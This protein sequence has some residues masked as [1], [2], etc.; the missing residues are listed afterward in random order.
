MPTKAVLFGNGGH[1]WSSL[2]NLIETRQDIFIKAFNLTTDY[3]GSGGIWYRLLE[4][5]DSQLSK[6]LYG[7]ARSVLPWGDYNKI[8][9]HYA[10]KRYGSLMGQ[11][12]D[13]RSNN[14]DKHKENFELLSD[15]MALEKPV[16][17]DFWQYFEIAFNY[18]QTHKKEL[19][20][21]TKKEFCFGY[22]W[23]DYVWWN[24]GGVADVNIFYHAK[25]IIPDNFEMHYTAKDRRVLT[26][27]TTT[28]RE[29]IGEDV[30]DNA[31]DPVL[32]ES[33]RIRTKALE[34][35]EQQFEF[36]N[37]GILEKAIRIYS[38]I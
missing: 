38:R 21:E 12:L 6:L 24:L 22:P 27:V 1:G 33:L 28:Y 13:F 25:N 3:G 29:L 17:D 7:E 15:M 4:H 23:Q 16:Y 26:G 35:C 31:I 2:E 19:K 14:I 32:P 5:D 8:V 20:Y 30:L 36:L 10:T 37:N 11:I 9:I 18:Y 34:V